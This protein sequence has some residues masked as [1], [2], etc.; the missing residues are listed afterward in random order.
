MALSLLPV[1]QQVKR[2]DDEEVC[3]KIAWNRALAAEGQEME[4]KQVLC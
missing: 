1:V 3:Y 4:I 2:R